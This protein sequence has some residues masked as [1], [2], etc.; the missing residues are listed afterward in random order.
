M[1][2]NM[3]FAGYIGGILLG[4]LAVVL[5]FFGIAVLLGLIQAIPAS[6]NLPLGIVILIVA[7]VLLLY[8]WYSYQSSKPKGTINVHNA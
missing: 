8:G 2:K 3:G 7:A 4:I 6:L 1:V 5:V